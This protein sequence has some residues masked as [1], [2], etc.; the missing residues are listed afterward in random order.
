MRIRSQLFT[1][2]RIRIQL[3]TVLRIRILLL[4]KVIW[5]CD[6][7]PI[8]PPGV[9]FEPPH[10]YCEFPWPSTAPVW[11]SIAHEFWLQCGSVSGSSNSTPMLSRIQ[12]PT[13][14][15][16][17][18]A[19]LYFSV[20]RWKDTI[21]MERCLSWVNFS[22]WMP[23]RES[24]PVH[25]LRQ[26]CALTICIAASY[27]DSILTGVSTDKQRSAVPGIQRYVGPPG[28]VNYLHSGSED[29]ILFKMLES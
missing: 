6:Q 21:N 18:S 3:F 28:S 12:L 11:A 9:H 19:I 13:I 17:G 8:G 2:M 27:P 5:I 7:L 23:G 22:P 29:K 16:Y 26:A 20:T 15:Q 4:I 24:N 10:L 1:S 14:M 25:T